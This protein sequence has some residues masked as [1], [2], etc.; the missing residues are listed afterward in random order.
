V[1]LPRKHIP[2]R[3]RFLALKASCMKMAVFW[4]VAQC[5]LIEVCRRFRCAYDDLSS[6]W[7]R[8]QRSQ[9][10]WW[11]SARLQYVTTQKTAIFI[12]YWFLC[13][14]IIPFRYSDLR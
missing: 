8:Q 1:K 3:L 13:V 6:W 11:T 7:W 12:P 14:I 5:N 4:V 9:K 10:R 2:Y